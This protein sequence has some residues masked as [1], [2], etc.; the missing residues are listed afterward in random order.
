MEGSLT[1][2]GQT[3]LVPQ[4][5]KVAFAFAV[6]DMVLMGRARKIGFFSQPSGRDLQAARQALDRVGLAHL[7]RRSF[8]ELSGGQRQLVILARALVAEAEILLM[9]EPTSALDLKNQDLVL[10]WMDRL[11]KKDGLTVIFT[12][13]HP[14]HALAVADR[15]FLMLEEGVR[16]DGTAEQTLTAENLRCLYGLPLQR[17]DFEYRGFKTSTITPVFLAPEPSSPEVP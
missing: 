12:T 9:D 6:L 5:F 1:V 4:I 14:H 3:A 7:E 11:T 2:D 10:R 16:L 17:L 13:H 15:A 8:H